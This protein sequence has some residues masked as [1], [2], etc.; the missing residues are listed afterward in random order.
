[1]LSTLLVKHTYIA[2]RDLT[3]TIIHR[4]SIIRA[5]SRSILQISLRTTN[6]NKLFSINWIVSHYSQRNQHEMRFCLRMFMILH[7]YVVENFKRFHLNYYESN[8]IL[9]I[10]FALNSYSIHLWVKTYQLHSSS[11]AVIC[12]NLGFTCCLVC[13]LIIILLFNTTYLHDSDSYQEALKY[14]HNLFLHILQEFY[15]ICWF[16]LSFESL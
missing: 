9:A 6:Q 10:C 16:S 14:K 13:W 1:M 3:M 11:S 5:S 12:I 8:T 4:Q 2:H 7:F 15:I